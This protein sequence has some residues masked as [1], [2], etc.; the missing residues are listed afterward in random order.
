MFSF[1]VIIASS[2][3]TTQDRPLMPHPPP[4]NNTN[5]TDSDIIYTNTIETGCG[6]NKTCYGENDCCTVTSYS[7]DDENFVEYQCMDSNL[8]AGIMDLM[9]FMG[10]ENV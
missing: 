5:Y 1:F 6:Q 3:S 7:K 9:E 2:Q 10:C 8:A 4:M